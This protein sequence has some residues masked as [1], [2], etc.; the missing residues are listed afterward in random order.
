MENTKRTRIAALLFI[1]LSLFAFTPAVYA[2]EGTVAPLNM[3]IRA[4]TMDENC[5]YPEQAAVSYSKFSDL[6]LIVTNDDPGFVTP[7]HLL[8]AYYQ[9]QGATKDTMKDYIQVNTDG[10]LCRECGIELPS[11]ASTQG[12][13]IGDH[14]LEVT[15]NMLEPGI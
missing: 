7:L 5:I 8:A 9:S 14:G 10:R 12:Q 4:T 3:T 1:C 6:G 13:Y 2:E 11:I 15:D